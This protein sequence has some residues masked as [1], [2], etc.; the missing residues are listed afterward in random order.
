MPNHGC[1]VSANE[2]SRRFVSR[3][4]AAQYAKLLLLLFL[5]VGNKVRGNK[6]KKTKQKRLACASAVPPRVSLSRGRTTC[7]GKRRKKNKKREIKKNPPAATSH[8]SEN[9]LGRVDYY[10]PVVASLCVG[11]AS[12]CVRPAAAFLGVVTM[13]T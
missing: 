3:V 11:L 12:A 4:C 7:E 9:A 1:G 8:P 10:Y 13:T 2:I 5:W 6:K